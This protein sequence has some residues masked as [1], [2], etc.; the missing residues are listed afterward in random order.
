MMIDLHTTCAIMHDVHMHSEEQGGDTRL[1]KPC[2]PFSTLLYLCYDPA[3]SSQ[4]SN[5]GLK[6]SE[7]IG[8]AVTN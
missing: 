7:P 2:I 4:G 8:N 5:W 3:R 1:S 6:L